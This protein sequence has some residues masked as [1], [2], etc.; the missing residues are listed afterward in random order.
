MTAALKR[1][2]HGLPGRSDTEV[3]AESLADPTRFADLVR[4]HGECI[5][6]YLTRRVGPDVAEDLA[7]ETFVKAFRARADYR[8]LNASALPWLYSIATNVLRSHIRS[9]QRR[10]A[11]LGRMAGRAVYDSADHERVDDSLE[12]AATLQRLAGSF[13]GLSDDARDILALIA[14]EGLS[15]EETAIALEVPVGTVR[16]RLSRARQEL[17]RA[18]GSVQHNL[19][20][21]SQEGAP[22]G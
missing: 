9:E 7:A 8:P 5:S 11:A 12:A 13:A 1:V 3:I 22:Y 16:S 21:A 15:Y 2:M 10:I 17:R 19:P 14:V 20:D 6:Q 18:L 4:V